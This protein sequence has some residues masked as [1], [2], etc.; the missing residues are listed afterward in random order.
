MFEGLAEEA[1]NFYAEA[2]PGSEI[3]SLER[4]PAGG[5]GPEG[6]VYQA[7]MNL[8]GQSV[9]F[10]D[11]PVSHGF[12][13][14]PAVSFFITCQEQ[15]EFDQI[16]AGLGESGQFLMPPDNYGFSQ[17]YAWLNDR[18]GVSWQISLP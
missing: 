18:F 16:V 2:I 9:R 4:Y 17:K 14:T 7:T 15:A 11:S 13:F 12:T 1:M 6:T 8:A 5:G 10:F 3:V